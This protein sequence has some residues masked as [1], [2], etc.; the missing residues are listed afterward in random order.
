MRKYKCPEC[1][2]ITTSMYCDTCQ[3]SIPSQCAIDNIENMDAENASVAS[4]AE[5]Q[6]IKRYTQENNYLLSQIERH[7]KVTAVIMVISMI[8]AAV[9]AASALIMFINF[10]RL[11]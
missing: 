8:C 4:T 9:S 2:K 11:F 7:T 5:L 6:D 10:S 3:K 1:G